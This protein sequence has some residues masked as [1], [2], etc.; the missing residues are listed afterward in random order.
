MPE[1]TPLTDEQ[2]A[3]Q[4]PAVARLVA[5]LAAIKAA[6]PHDPDPRVATVAVIDALDAYFRTPG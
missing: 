3:E 6:A 5:S 4:F 2:L 1:A